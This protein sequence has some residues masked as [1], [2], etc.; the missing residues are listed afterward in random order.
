MLS[1]I[2]IIHNEVTGIYSIN[3]VLYEDNGEIHYALDP[4]AEHVTHE[5]A[6]QHIDEMYKA[7]LKPLLVKTLTGEWE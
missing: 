2:R 1:D 6:L 5:G 7:S 4:L 3:R